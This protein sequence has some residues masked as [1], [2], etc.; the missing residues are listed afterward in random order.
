MELEKLKV[1]YE[2]ELESIRINLPAV[3]QSNFNLYV[4]KFPEGYGKFKMFSDASNCDMVA[5]CEADRLDYAMSERLLNQ[6][7][8]KGGRIVLLRDE[9]EICASRLIK[10]ITVINEVT[11]SI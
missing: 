1:Q 8:I 9:L 3:K 5:L 11:T 2:S 7:H 10:A 6:S 4:C